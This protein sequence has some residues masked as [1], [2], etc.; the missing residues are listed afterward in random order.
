ML[1]ICTQLHLQVLLLIYHKPKQPCI[2]N[3][4]CSHF[5]DNYNV[6]HVSAMYS[7]EDVVKLLLSKK[8][9]DPYATGGVSTFTSVLLTGNRFACWTVIKTLYFLCY[10][11]KYVPR[12]LGSDSFRLVREL[13]A[14]QKGSL[15]TFRFSVSTTDSGA[16]GR[17]KTN[18]NGYF[19]PACLASSRWEGYSTKTGRSELIKIFNR[20]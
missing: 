7:R 19:N 5:Q 6:L 9:V 17:F 8:G 12:T 16:S 11:V 18:R 2:S 1:I 13:V 15:N 4:F 3:C 20:F 10:G 14:I